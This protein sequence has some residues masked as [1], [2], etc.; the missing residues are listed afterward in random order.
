MVLKRPFFDDTGEASS[1]S[2]FRYPRRQSLLG[3]SFTEKMVLKKPIFGDT[4]KA[5]AHS[6]FRSQYHSVTLSGLLGDT[7]HQVDMIGL[8]GRWLYKGQI[9]KPLH[10]LCSGLTAHRAHQVNMIGLLRRWLCKGCTGKPLHI[11]SGHLGDRAPR[12]SRVVLERCS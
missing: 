1:H 11:Q 4:G 5:S 8:L 3:D 7:A 10:I 6:M 9:G 2:M 12:I